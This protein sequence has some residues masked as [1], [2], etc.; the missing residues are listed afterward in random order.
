MH[1]NSQDASPFGP[2]HVLM[3]TVIGELPGNFRWAIEGQYGRR[4]VGLDRYIM[5]IRE[6]VIVELD[7][8]IMP[9][10]E[11]VIVEL[12]WHIISSATV[13]LDWTSVVV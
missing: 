1:T 12:D 13:N 9:I 4:A 6:C 11:W 3:N 8:H 5:P 7:R 10:R 2:H